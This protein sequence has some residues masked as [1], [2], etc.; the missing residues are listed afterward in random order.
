MIPTLSQ[1]GEFGLI[2]SLKKYAGKS[3]S[4]IEGIG[5]DAAVV[6]FNAK[7]YLLLTADMLVEGTHFTADMPAKAV[8][9]KAMAC[10]ISDIAAMGGT[11]KYAV[12]SL[13]APA[14]IPA[15]YIYGLY[16]G[17]NATARKFKTVIVGG[18]TVRSKGLV[19]N[20]AMAGEADKNAVVTRSGARKGDWIFVTG[21]LGRSFI[22]GGHLRFTPRLDEAQF[23][24]KH[25]KPSAMIDISDGLAGDLG[26]MLTRSCAGAILD[27][28]SIPRR[29][30]A[31]LDASLY[32][33]EDFEL[34]FT[35][36]PRQ[37]KGLRRAKR[38]NFNFYRIGEIVEC[39]KGLQLRMPDGTCRDLRRKGYTHF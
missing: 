18:D 4:I 27:A 1:I 11:P 33:G 2:D 23:L 13:G 3:A 15:R 24:V 30:G 20:V 34:L 6:A 36:S 32:G 25:H 8:G 39:R 21:P 26:H 37:A 14:S 29:R 22:S 17:M 28:G 10:S 7:K 5:D 19:I 35:V 12:I 16:A 31:T 38:K 9:H